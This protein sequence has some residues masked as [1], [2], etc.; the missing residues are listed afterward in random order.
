M[1]TN[2]VAKGLN[3]FIGTKWILA[4]LLLFGAS[5]LWL[6]S[7]FFADA[8]RALVAGIPIPSDPFDFV[9]IFSLLFLGGF[10]MAWGGSMLQ[11]REWGALAGGMVRLTLT[12][13]L[14]VGAVIFLRDSTGWLTG[15]VLSFYNRY[16]WL[17]WTMFGLGILWLLATTWFLLLSKGR[18]D[19]YA[20]AYQDSPAPQIPTCPQC[21]LMLTD[22][23]CPEHDMQKRSAYLKISDRREL[24]PFAEN[25]ITFTI[26]RQKDN[27]EAYITLSVKDTE[28]AQRISGR[29]ASIQYDFDYQQF[30]IQDLASLNKTYL[31]DDPEPLPPNQPYPLKHGDKIDLAHEVDLIF[32]CDDNPT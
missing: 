22:G 10:S 12:I 4:G 18:R 9:V 5:L 23:R 14:L 20:A 8:F 29:H 16:A 2:S 13:Y 11:R 3:N 19:Y 31:N 27:S 7:I 6:L 15:S 25:A 24:L 28:L 1:R 17:V 30:T 32:E 26:G 21:G